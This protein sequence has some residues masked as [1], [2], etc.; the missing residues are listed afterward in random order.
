M[1]THSITNVTATTPIE[2]SVTAR[3]RLGAQTPR[4]LPL[5]ILEKTVMD[6]Q[7]EGQPARCNVRE[8]G[9]CTAHAQWVD[10]ANVPLSPCLRS[11][12]TS[13]CRRQNTQLS[14]VGAFLRKARCHVLCG[15]FLPF[16]RKDGIIDSAHSRA[17]FPSSSRVCGPLNRGRGRVHLH[18]GEAEHRG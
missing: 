10:R 7:A 4:C 2:S 14:M 8:H 9:R 5:I 1:A 16:T 12:G 13:L 15:C 18:G 3:A 11:P 6:K 17:H